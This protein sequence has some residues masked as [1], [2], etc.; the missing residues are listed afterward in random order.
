MPAHCPGAAGV[1]PM[2]A[3][4]HGPFENDGAGHFLAEIRH[5]DFTFGG[6]WAFEDP[7]YLE[8]DGGQIA[9]PLAALVRVTHG[10]LATPEEVDAASV[11]A[12]AAQLNPERLE[13]ITAQFERT[14]SD[15]EASEL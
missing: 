8:A 4:G 7:D 3:W 1:S 14:L 9:V 2:G 13:W 5:G 11:E 12:F 10:E 15:G 6:E